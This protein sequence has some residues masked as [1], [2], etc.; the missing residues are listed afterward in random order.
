YA[1][2]LKAL[3]PLLSWSRALRLFIRSQPHSPA[4]STRVTSS[5]R[6]CLIFIWSL[7]CGSLELCHQPDLLHAGSFRDVDR[8]DDVAVDQ[9][10]GALDEDGLVGTG[11]V[12]LGQ[13]LAQRV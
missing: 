2:F 4:T 8:L 3:T 7:P 10:L 9:S 1:L 11:A 5:V 13:P 6:K 12:D